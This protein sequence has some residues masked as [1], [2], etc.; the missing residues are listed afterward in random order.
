MVD[1]LEGYQGVDR[2]Q[3]RVATV[4]T[5]RTGGDSS[6][7]GAGYE[8][9]CLGPG[10]VAV[11]DYDVALGSTAQADAITATTSGEGVALGRSAVADGFGTTAVGA[12]SYAQHESATALG[13]LAFAGHTYATAIGHQAVTTAT[14]QIM[15][16]RAED[17]VRVPGDLTV[18]GTFSNPSARHL[19]TSIKPARCLRDVFPTRYEY[20]YIAR[21]GE[22][23]LGHMADE[24]AGTDA[25]RFVTTDENGD[26]AIDYQGLH[27]AQIYALRAENED[28]RT[29][30]AVLENLVKGLTNG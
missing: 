19:K 9:L 3:R 15:L 21:P 16:G 23:R 25:E 5:M 28:L 10:A 6:H 4:E 20:E 30:V 29:R 26:E 2:L 8:S 11:N 13:W 17:T 27:G 14:H 22:R 24:L 1:H 12:R 18:V 7:A